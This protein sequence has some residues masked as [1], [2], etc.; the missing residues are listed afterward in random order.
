LRYPVGPDHVPRESI[1]PIEKYPKIDGL[2][3]VSKELEDAGIIYREPDKNHPKYKVAQE[4]CK[5][6]KVID[7]KE[8]EDYEKNAREMATKKAKKKEEMSKAHEHMHKHQR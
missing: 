4:L 5:D 2:P 8:L 6:E 1:H 3:Y 7:L